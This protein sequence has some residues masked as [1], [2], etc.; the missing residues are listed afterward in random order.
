MTLPLGRLRKSYG[1]PSDCA[2]SR[3]DNIPRFCTIA[4]MNGTSPAT[5]PTESFGAWLRREAVR[6]LKVSALLLVAGLAFVYALD[7][8]WPKFSDRWWR[9]NYQLTHTAL[10]Q[11][12]LA[13]ARNFGTR[14]GASEYG[15][16]LLSWSLPFNVTEAQEDLQH[17]YPEFVGVRNGAP[18]VKRSSALRRQNRVAAYLAR[19]QQIESRRFTRL[20]APPDPFSPPDAN[21]ELGQVITKLLGLPDAAIHTVRQIVA[22]GI[23]SILLFSTVLALSAVALWRSHRPARRWLKLLV[24]PTLASAL[25]W[26][27]IV[28]MSLGSILG[29]TFTDNTSAIALLTALPF[30]FLAAKLPLRYAETLALAKPPTP[31]KWDGVD[32]RKNRGPATPSEPTNPAL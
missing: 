10:E 9:V 3:R 13:I 32:R 16:G 20:Y 14:L 17:D 23:M 5:G 21:A 25:I 27:A 22:G 11:H 31:A 8:M 12:P 28:A 26:V 1:A 30:L 24:W 6:A 18:I 4:P 15:W 7:A 19:H 29:G 2:H